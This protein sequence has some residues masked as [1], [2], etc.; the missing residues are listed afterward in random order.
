MIRRARPYRFDSKNQVISSILIGLMILP[1]LLCFGE[2]FKRPVHPAPK[3]TSHIPEVVVEWAEPLEDCDNEKVCVQGQ[4][5]NAGGK[6]AYNIYLRIEIGGTKYI[7]PKTYLFT[8][9]EE[10][11]MHPNERQEFY[12]EIDRKVHYKE[13]GKIKAIEVGKYN[14]KIVPLWTKKEKISKKEKKIRARRLQKSRNSP[15]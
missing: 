8:R 9:V 15:F 13:R 1:P 10:T 3:R 11:F 12:F 6:T 5:L 7:K 14:Y 2:P 4:L